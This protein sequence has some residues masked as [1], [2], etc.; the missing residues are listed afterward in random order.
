M[1]ITTQQ[2]RRTA[3]LLFRWC[4]R[5]GK[6]DKQRARQVMQWI[7]Q[8][9][10]RGYLT[11]LEQLKYLIKLQ[12]AKETATI[13]SAVSLPLDVRIRIRAGLENAYGTMITTAFAQNP[14]LIGGLRIQVGSDVYDGSVQ[15]RLV[16]LKT[17]FG[18]ADGKTPVS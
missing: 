5:D 15:A 6:L 16:A 3:R 12:R 14:A 2:A 1:A 11:L 17:Q 13:E 4:L 9:K 8:S 7:L 18:I 10:R